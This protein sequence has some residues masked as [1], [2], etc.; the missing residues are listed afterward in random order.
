MSFILGP[1]VL[2]RCPCKGNCISV[3]S[4]QPCQPHKEMPC[5]LV[6]TWGS[7]AVHNEMWNIIFDA[8]RTCFLLAFYCFITGSP[9]LSGASWAQLCPGLC[10]CLTE[11]RAHRLTQD[12]QWSLRV[13]P[14]M[15][16]N[17][18]GPLPSCN[19]FHTLLSLCNSGGFLLPVP[20]RKQQ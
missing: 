16:A 11:L 7:F 3:N 1:S 9:V 17:D 5:R 14:V 20:C 8:Q 2:G 4:A 6:R 15:R 13:V 18:L 10:L 19:Q 12:R